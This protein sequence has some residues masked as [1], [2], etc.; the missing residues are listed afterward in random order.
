MGER[1]TQYSTLG[2]PQKLR[3]STKSVMCEPC[4]RAG[5]KPPERPTGNIGDQTKALSAPD[6]SLCTMC[7]EPTL[8]QL[9][10]NTA[11]S[12]D[13]DLCK[14]CWN[15]FRAGEVL[16]S[17]VPS[18]EKPLPPEE[19]F[20]EVFRVARVLL[21]GR[22]NRL[23]T[24]RTWNFSK[25][26]NSLLTAP[27]HI[28]YSPIGASSYYRNSSSKPGSAYTCFRSPDLRMARFGPYER[29]VCRNPR[30]KRGL[31]RPLPGVL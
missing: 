16:A 30:G 31:E 28:S 24:F 15:K 20:E 22:A 8:V 27:C 7:G 26:L 21:R 18:T 9:F 2:E 25:R 14:E 10:S 17:F 23:A 1:C 13:T 11:Q 3:R 4:Q 29:R 6:H 12:S 19:K 5:L